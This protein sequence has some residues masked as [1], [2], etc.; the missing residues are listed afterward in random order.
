[1]VIFGPF[2]GCSLTCSRLHGVTRVKECVYLLDFC[3]SACLVWLKMVHLWL[4]LTMWHCPVKA[5]CL[6]SQCDCNQ[7]SKKA[8]LT[9]VHDAWCDP[10]VII[11]QY[12]GKNEVSGNAVA[13]TCWV[14][15]T[16]GLGPNSEVFTAQKHV[17]T[18]RIAQ[19]VI[20]QH[21][22]RCMACQLEASA[23]CACNTQYP[24]WQ[25][26]HTQLPEQQKRHHNDI[27]NT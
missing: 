24:I 23:K 4:T 20:G 7:G 26:F 8:W 11:G 18:F 13:V 14:L 2:R 15:I 6:Q 1:M 25:N 3:F 12:V 10:P 21:K 22:T 5:K 16:S 27:Q 17:A 19:I 9:R